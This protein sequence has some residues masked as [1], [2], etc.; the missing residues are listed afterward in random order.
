LFCVIHLG[1]GRIINIVDPD[2]VD[3][4]M[5]VNFWAYEKGDRLRSVLGPLVGQGK[6]GDR[7]RSLDTTG[8]KLSINLYTLFLGI[9]GADGEH[10]KWQRKLGKEERL[11]QNIVLLNR[12][13]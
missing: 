11:R 8:G 9:F 13:D 4:V 7:S 12:L 10:W 5:R 6:T 1:V 3:H 2:M